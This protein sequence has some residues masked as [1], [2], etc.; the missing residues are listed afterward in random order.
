MKYIRIKNT[1]IIE[2]QALHLVGA[3]SKRNDSTKIGQFGSGNKYALAYLL[4]N[5]YEVK[6]FAGMNEI[7]V[8]T[9]SEKFRDIDF[10][11]IYLNGERTSIT[12]DMGKDWEFW[13]AIRELYCN[14][15][16]EGGCSMDFVQTIQPTESETHFYIDTH[17]DIM[18]FVT[19]FDNYFATNKKVLFECESGRILEKSGITANIYR[20]GIKCFITT[21]NS[22]Y[23]YDFTSMSINE[24]RLVNYSWQIEEKIWDLLFQCDN[25]EVIMQ[26]LHSVSAVDYLE[27]CISDAAD[28]VSS[29]A[30]DK[31]KECMEKTNLVPKGYAG[32]LKADEV[33]S[34]III[35][36]K[37]FQSIR[38]IIPEANLADNFRVTKWGAIFRVIESTQLY[39]ITIQNALTFLNECRFP[40]PYD[41]KVAVFDNKAVLGTID[42]DVIILSDTCVEKGINEIVNTLIEEFIHIKYSARDETRSFQTAIITEFI[43]YM[44]NTNAYAI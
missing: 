43:S 31:F 39:K 25:E 13:Q 14:A 32:L 20:K 36:T 11:I 12:T 17:K 44:K 27:G 3:S 38:G 21:K 42:G 4:R 41:I 34:Y 6:I 24:N 30:S 7:K 10:N 19:N 22:K 16:D 1:G 23:D 37:V 28:I 9:R 26:V 18:E 15:L 33:Q 40:I 2:T 8:E 29:K 5:G 35:P